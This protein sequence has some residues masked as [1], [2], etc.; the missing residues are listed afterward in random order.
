M[1]SASRAMVV[2][3]ITFVGSKQDD[4]QCSAAVA[5]TKGGNDQAFP[6]QEAESAG[7]ADPDWC[8]GDRHDSDASGLVPAIVNTLQ[9][10]SFTFRG[11]SERALL[12]TVGDDVEGRLLR[13]SQR[14]RDAATSRETALEDP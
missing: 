3:L 9:R 7:F 6:H 10:P 13:I 5:D 2:S 4:D 11:P 1:S 12:L 14:S 8:N